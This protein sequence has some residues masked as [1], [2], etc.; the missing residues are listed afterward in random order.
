MIDTHSDQPDQNATAIDGA[1]PGD[2]APPAL[3]EYRNPAGLKPSLIAPW[4]ILGASLVGVLVGSF[5]AVLGIVAACGVVLMPHTGNAVASALL[6]IC[7][8]SG[9][10]VL[11]YGAIAKCSIVCTC[12]V[13][14]LAFL[15]AIPMCRSTM[16]I[17]W[18][19]FDEDAVLPGLVMAA[20]LYSTVGHFIWASRLWIA[21]RQGRL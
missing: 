15:V 6:W 21:R 1:A 16:Y 11:E 3:I 20:A 19:S 18:H 13:G 12:L 5:L 7:V 17:L 10:L 2:A 4:Y 8:G 9:I 14:I